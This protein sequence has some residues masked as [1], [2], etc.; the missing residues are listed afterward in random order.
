MKTSNEM[1]FIKGKEA[2]ITKF[3]ILI[4]VLLFII[5]IILIFLL[6]SVYKSILIVKEQTKAVVPVNGIL[7]N[8]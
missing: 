2:V 5:P 7:E 8:V 4:A 3:L 6:R 1:V